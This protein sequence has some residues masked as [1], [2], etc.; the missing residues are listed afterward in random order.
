M[1]LI[2]VSFLNVN[3]GFEDK[4]EDGEKVGPLIDLWRK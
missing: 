2:T 1:K 3:K 4:K